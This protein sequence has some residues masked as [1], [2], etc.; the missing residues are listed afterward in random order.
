MLIPRDYEDL[1]Y[2]VKDLITGFFIEEVKKL[3]DSSTTLQSFSW[4]QFTA[5]GDRESKKYTVYST[6]NTPT[7]NGDA[8][9]WSTEAAAV[10]EFLSKFKPEF[11]ILGFGSDC[12]VTVFRDLSFSIV[13]DHQ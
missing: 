9:N 4:E 13:H 8:Y 6:K 5:G 10:A 1:T 3:F 12:K 7:I 11:L 2:K